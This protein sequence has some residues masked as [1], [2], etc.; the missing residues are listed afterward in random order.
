MSDEDLQKLQAELQGGRAAVAVLVPPDE[1]AATTA[2]LQKLGGT[3]QSHDVSEE[4]LKSAHEAIQTNPEVAAA[5]VEAAAPETKA[6]A[7]EVAADP[8]PATTATSAPT[9]TECF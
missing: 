6:V 2:E 4:D 7:P 3:T 5:V 1:V 9:N 8:A